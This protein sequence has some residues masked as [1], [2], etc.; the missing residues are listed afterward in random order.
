[1]LLQAFIVYL[2][3]VY[4]EKHENVMFADISKC[5]EPTNKQLTFNESDA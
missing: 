3:E 2:N 5:D 4:I 1:M